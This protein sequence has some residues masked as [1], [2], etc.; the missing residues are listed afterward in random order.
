MTDWL[1]RLYRNTL[2]RLTLLTAFLFVMGSLIA[3]GYTYYATISSE[4]RRVNSSLVAEAQELTELFETEG[5]TAVSRE[6][7]IRSSAM[8]EGLYL[9]S[10]GPLAT[11]NING[12]D[13]LTEGPLS[14]S[15]ERGILPNSEREYNRFT[16]SY[17]LGA[18]ADTDTSDRRAFALATPLVVEGIPRGTLVLARDVETTLRNAERIRSAIVLSALIAFG[19]GLLS[20]AFVSQRFSRRIEAFNKLATDV[21]SGNMKVRAER[22]YSEDELDLLA[23]NLNDML[24]HIDQLMAA[25]RYAGDSIAHDLR[26]PLT[27]LRT[28]L[29]TAVADAD[30]ESAEILAS[31]AED[32]SQLLQ[33][34]D[35]VLR[36]A[37]LES[38][39]RREP[40][41]VIDPAPL[42]EDIAELY[43]PAFEDAGLTFETDIVPNTRIAADRGLVSQ[44]VSNLVENAIKY[45][46]EGGRVE[47]SLRRNRLGQPT[48]AVTDDGPG[49][50]IHMRERIRER[51]V[52]LEE[53]RSR[54]GSGLGLSLVEAVA[55]VHKAEFVI[56]DGFGDLE[57]GGTP[58]MR[59]ALVFPKVRSR[60]SAPKVANPQAAGGV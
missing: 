60:P 58:G 32:A 47:L 43:E 25:M 8:G 50:P 4:L 12:L 36:I 35:S 13:T 14:G 44:A 7:T 6:V 22:N 5:I 21:R 37:R 48:I 17:A 18:G 24:D 59:A 40:L 41:V 29:E 26:S 49:I 42:L 55:E 34:F 19:F 1:V 46:P 39:D 45:V 30:P 16:F 20:A 52:R 28:R 27:R 38:A 10:F 54:P 2:F 56:D 15:V 53:S 23:E 57:A 9:L 51:F 3:L 31:S 33:T 11:G